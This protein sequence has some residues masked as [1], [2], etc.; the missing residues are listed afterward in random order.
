MY[1]IIAQAC[2]ETK[3]NIV[4]SEAMIL[5]NMYSKFYDSEIIGW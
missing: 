3:Q 1:K 2:L 5:Q 4:Q